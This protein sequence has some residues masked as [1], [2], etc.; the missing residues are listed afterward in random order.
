MAHDRGYTR[1]T[2]LE[3]DTLVINTSAT[4][5][6]GAQASAGD[7][8]ITAGNLI[9]T[10]ASAKII[11]GATSLLIRN[12]G[13]T[14]SN[15]AVTDAGVVTIT[16]ASAANA[17]LIV[18]STNASAFAVGRLGGTTPAFVVDASAATSITGIKITSAASG[19]GVAIAAV[20]E[21][22]NGNLTIDAQGS[23]TLTLNGTATGN[24]VLGRA[25]TGVSLSVTGAVTSKSGTAVP[26]TAGAAAAGAPI[27][28]NSNG[29]TIEWTTDPPTHT[30][31]KGSICINLGGS[32]S[33]TR[34]YV[35][36]D[37]AGT[38][39]AITTAS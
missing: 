20:G 17:R 11:P 38:W 2:K 7:L 1:F 4:Y 10:A 22:S 9:F 25:A 30:R 15:I 19:N 13:D 3:V 21:A 18:Q 34:L 35:N 33:S 12:T 16:G 37:G 6:G 5:P 26:A 27:V 39:V 23:G 36:S 8:T 14:A 32:S 24:I 28:A 29:M 31:P